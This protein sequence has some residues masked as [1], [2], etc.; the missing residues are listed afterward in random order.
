M[1]LSVVD[2][3]RAHFTR[4]FG[5]SESRIAIAPGRVN[6][7]GEHTDYNDGFVLPLA[8]DRHAVVAFRP[9]SDRR[10]RAYAVAFDETREAAIET[11]VPGGATGWFAY[12]A[13]VAW[14]LREEGYDPPGLD[15]VLQGTVPAGAGLSSSAAVELAAAR[16]FQADLPWDALAMARLGQRAENRFVGVSCGLMDQ[17]A[18]AVSRADAAL[19]L[20][21][22]SLAY[23]AVPVPEAAT[24]AILDTG[25]RRALAESAY[26][27]RRAACE[28]AVRSLAPRH[29]G[30]TALRDVDESMLEAGRS[31]LSETTFRRALHVVREIGRPVALA[32]ALR[33]GDLALAG[34][35]MND[36]H[37]SLRD[38]YEVSSPELDLVSELARAHPAC[39]GA[40][41]T[42]AGFGG[43]AIALVGTAE[44]ASFLAEVSQRYRAQVDLPS[45][46]FA[47]RPE[48]GARLLP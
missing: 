45:A 44:V 11:L 26:N 19:L 14:A 25:A 35:L 37:Q 39:F 29:P 23:E 30:V 27:D 32:A 43:C 33:G 36:S 4:L 12:V 7:I 2:Q 47:C 18:A 42:G 41:M 22:R 5:S 28:E 38:L 16:A 31:L 3:A 48:A 24:I 6:L 21:C 10:L 17:F 40:R 1:T 15:M 8:I 34:R 13:G 20:D 9:R 46:F